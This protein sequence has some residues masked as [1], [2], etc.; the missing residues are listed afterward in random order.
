MSGKVVI[1]ESMATRG[2]PSETMS[3]PVAQPMQSRRLLGLPD[4][5]NRNRSGAD[6][7]FGA[8]VCLLVERGADVVADALKPEDVAARAGKSRASYYRTDG[9]PSSVT[10][11]NEARRAALEE[12]LGR[13]LRAG[14]ADAAASAGAV[15][16]ALRPE[17]D[18]DSASSAIHQIST[19]RFDFADE[20]PFLVELLSAALAPSS[21]AVATSLADYYDSITASYTEMARS[22]LASR[23]YGVRSPLTERDLVVLVLALADGLA[24]RRMGDDDIDS[25]YF[26]VA[27]GALVS[28]LV[29][30]SH[31]SHEVVARSV[32]PGSLGQPPTRASIIEALARLFHG[33]R[34]SMPTI[35]ELAVAA[36]CTDQTIRSLFGGVV[37]VVHAAW[38]EWLPEFEEAAERERRSQTAPDSAAVLYRVMTQIAARAIE[39]PALTRALLMSEIAHEHPGTGDSRR[40]PLATLLDRLLD[41]ATSSGSF[42]APTIRNS[43]VTT[44]HNHL[45]ARSLR[46]QLLHVSAGESLPAGRSVEQHARWCADYVWAVMMAGAQQPGNGA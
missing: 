43:A 32:D 31:E 41:D 34:T 15:A 14:A 3:D 11:N 37:G 36:G 16:E 30:P 38:H 21:E 27:V 40:E 24:M 19:S 12:A 44:D 45:F 7:L 6:R 29:V 9:F 35:T 46:N 18:I 5:Q 28:A 20:A 8:I 17:V 10:H 39:H 25:A 42:R 22:V 23:G 1:S 33:S 2:V 26:G 13:V 4:P